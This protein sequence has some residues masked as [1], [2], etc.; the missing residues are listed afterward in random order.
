MTAASQSLT[1]TD[2]ATPS[3]TGAETA[4]LVNPAAATHFI[5]TG[6]SSITAGTAFNI[7]VTA[8]DTYGNIATGYL[9]TIGFSSTDSHASLP[10]NYTFTTSD[11][12]VHTFKGLKLRTKG[13]Q[14]IN[15]FDVANTGIDGSLTLSVQ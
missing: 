13:T 1:A 11:Q 9:G 12:G 4:I 2:T 8:V 14:T 7:T 3:M 6:P 15:V 10:G 5:I